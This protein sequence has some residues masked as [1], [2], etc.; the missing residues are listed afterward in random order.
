MQEESETRS[1]AFYLFS[2]REKTWALT[3]LSTFS[4]L[5]AAKNFIS[6]R[7]GLQFDDPKLRIFGFVMEG[8]T[9]VV[10]TYWI[11]KAKNKLERAFVALWLTGWA[12]GW[13]A[14][15]YND[16]GLS[17][18]RLATFL[19]WLAATVIALR[20]MKAANALQ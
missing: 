15:L 18:V 10:L 8:F 6:P 13:F 20:I 1:S 14:P 17:A 4:L 11:A 12:I 5:M 9:A 7:L 3:G 16:A 19:I 2:S